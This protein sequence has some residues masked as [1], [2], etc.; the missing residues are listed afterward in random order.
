M[1]GIWSG[2]Q[3]LGSSCVQSGLRLGT[4]LG[5]RI[6]NIAY[7]GLKYGKGTGGTTN[8]ET[9]KTAFSL[10]QYSTVLFLMP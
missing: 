6:G 1:L 8:K 10:V 7:F 5:F 9:M 2:S 4:D 3:F